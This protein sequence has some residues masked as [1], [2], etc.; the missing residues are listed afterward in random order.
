MDTADTPPP[1]IFDYNHLG[2]VMSSRDTLRAYLVEALGIGADFL[3]HF[4]AID[5]ASALEETLEFRPDHVP[6]E[7]Y[8]KS[9][10]LWIMY[11]LLSRIGLKDQIS[12]LMYAVPSS[13]N[14][15]PRTHFLI[16][17]DTVK[18]KLETQPTVPLFQALEEFT[19]QVVGFNRQHGDVLRQEKQEYVERRC[20]IIRWFSW[21]V[22]KGG[23]DWLRT[24]TL[25]MLAQGLHKWRTEPP[26][27]E[28]PVMAAV[29]MLD[30]NSPVFSPRRMN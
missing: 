12:A 23:H 30:P 24:A 11:K 21:V 15:A 19:E 29:S 18:Y 27:P 22:C 26:A 5:W 7:A 20:D 10:H 28:T 16:M 13:T 17:L 2:Y 9:Q 4:Q 3:D 8:L 1:T 6:T 25:V 14:T